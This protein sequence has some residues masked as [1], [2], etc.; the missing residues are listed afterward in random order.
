MSNSQ[1]HSDQAIGDRALREDA[2][3]HGKETNNWIGKK[4]TLFPTRDRFGGKQVDCIRIRDYVD[5]KSAA[6]TQPDPPDMNPETG[7]FPDSVQPAQ[8]PTD[9]PQPEREPGEEP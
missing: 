5:G 2:E 6:P 1:W 9:E 4:I 8:L 3:L 7:E